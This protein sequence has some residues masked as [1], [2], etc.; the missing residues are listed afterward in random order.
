MYRDCKFIKQQYKATVTQPLLVSSNPH[1]VC[2]T[3]MCKSQENAQ[4]ELSEH[5]ANSASGGCMCK[6]LKNTQALT[7]G[8]QY[9]F[10]IT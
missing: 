5:T 4:A 8:P 6:R 7:N 2:Q 10:P 1:S 3:A 9:L